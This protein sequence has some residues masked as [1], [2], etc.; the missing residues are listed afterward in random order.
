MSDVLCFLSSFLLPKGSK[1]EIKIEY[2]IENEIT[3]PVSQGDVI[4][5]IVF[6]L[7]GEKLGESD[8]KSTETVEKMNFGNAFLRMLKYT[9]TM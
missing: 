9:F 5:K 7:N 8:I 4:G 3:S 2:L 1:K 6:T